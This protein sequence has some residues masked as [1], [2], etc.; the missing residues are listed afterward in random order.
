MIIDLVLHCREETETAKLFNCSV[1]GPPLSYSLLCSLETLESQ[2]A[3]K[4]RKTNMLVFR[5][6][7][8]TISLSL[9]RV[10]ISNALLL[11]RRGQRAYVKNA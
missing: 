2:K 8:Q 3:R 10:G 1:G 9:E 11:C 7:T 6:S 5:L 4:S